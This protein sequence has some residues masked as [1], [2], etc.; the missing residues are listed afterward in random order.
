MRDERASFERKNLI[1]KTLI[2]VVMFMLSLMASILYIISYPVTTIRIYNAETQEFIDKMTVRRNSPLDYII[3][4]ETPY[5]YDFKCYTYE[6]GSEFVPGKVVNQEVINIYAVY[7]AK[8]FRVTYYVQDTDGEYNT[9]VDG[10]ESFL[11]QYGDTFNLPTGRINGTLQGIF[12]NNAGRS[13]IGWTIDELATDGGDA[14]VYAPGS[15]Q[16]VTGDLNYYAAWE[17][18][19]YSVNLWT[20]NDYVTTD[21]TPILEGG[22]PKRDGSG[23]FIIKNDRL[24]VDNTLST[25]RYLDDLDLLIDNYSSVSLSE[26]LDGLGAE[27][28]DFLGWY[29]EDNYVT[30]I[31]E[32]DIYIDVSSDGVPY[33]GYK[34]DGQKKELK[35]AREVG[36]D[37]DGNGV[38]QFDLYAKWQRRAYNITFDK[39]SN[40][41]KG[42]IDKIQVYKYDELYG[43]F[44]NEGVGGDYAQVSN[45]TR[46]GQK[47][48]KYYNYINLSDEN[49]ITTKTFKESY[50]TST[51]RKYKFVGWTTNSNSK[52]DGTKWYC[53]YLVKNGEEQTNEYKHLVGKDITLYAQ[54]EPIWEIRY[55]EST[56]SYS[57]YKVR[58]GI[59]GETV[60]LCGSAEVASWGWSLKY[61]KFAGWTSSKTSIS[62][63]ILK[64]ENQPNFTHKF[65]KQD[66]VLYVVW[67][68][69]KY[70]VTYMKNDGTNDN[71][72]SFMTGYTKFPGSDTAKNKFPSYVPQREGY[73]FEGWSSY[74][75]QTNEYA[76]E[77]RSGTPT[78]EKAVYS[79]GSRNLK[80]TGNTVVYAV[81]SVNYVITYDANGGEG[82]VNPDVMYSSSN[83]NKKLKMSVKG[84]G[85]KSKVSKFG[86][87]FKGWRL[88]DSA[89]NLNTAY[90][91]SSSST[92][93]F[94][95]IANGTYGSVSLSSNSSK[96]ANVY[97]EKSTVEGVPDRVI[98]LVAQ[99]EPIS[100]TLTFINTAEGHIEEKVRVVYGNDY[101]FDVNY[102]FDAD[103]SKFPN[104]LPMTSS[105]GK[106]FDGWSL[107]RGTTAKYGVGLIDTLTF[108]GSE[109]FI[110]SDMTFYSIF[111]VKPIDVYFKVE[112]YN[113]DPNAE[114][115]IIDFVTPTVMNYG[116][117]ITFPKTEPSE[118]THFGNDLYKF[119]HW[120][121]IDSKTGEKV[122]VQKG[123][124][125]FN[126]VEDKDKD[127]RSL[128]IWAHFE[129][130]VYDIEFIFATPDGKQQGETYT[131]TVKKDDYYTADL[132]KEVKK[133]FEAVIDEDTIKSHVFEDFFNEAYV[134]GGG[135]DFAKRLV[136]GQQFNSLYFP[137]LA[138]SK[139]LTFKTYWTPNSVNIKYVYENNGETDYYVGGS[140]LYDSVDTFTLETFDRET[141]HP[142]EVEDGYDIY[143]WYI[144]KD[145]SKVYFNLG[146]RL[147]GGA[148]PSM[149]SLADYIVWPTSGTD[150]SGTLY[151][152]AEVNENIT[153]N[154]YGT[155]GLIGTD[156]ILLDASRQ[157]SVTIKNGSEATKSYGRNNN[158]RFEGWKVGGLSETT[159]W[160][161]GATISVS[162]TAYPSHVINLYADM[163]FDI[164]YLHMKDYQKS[165]NDA[166]VLK[167]EKVSLIN[168]SKTGYITFY[169]SKGLDNLDS[170]KD[171]DKGIGVFGYKYGEAI[172]SVSNVAN[173]GLPIDIDGKTQFV[174]LYVYETIKI[175]YTVNVNNGERFSHET[176]E[177]D[178]EKATSEIV[179][180]YKVGY[181][182]YCL[183]GDIRVIS[184]I[185][186]KPDYEHSG[187]KKTVNGVVN[188]TV[189]KNSEI[190]KL[191]S[192][193]DITMQAYFIEPPI[194][195]YTGYLR[196]KADENT[197]HDITVTNGQ[198]TIEEVNGVKK[199][200][201]LLDEDDLIELDEERQG[202]GKSLAWTS[203]KKKIIGW[204]CGEIEYIL[205]AN[206]P[207]SRN[208]KDND[209]II[210]EAIWEKTYILSYY[211]D[212]MDISKMPNPSEI[213]VVSGDVCVV[214]IVVPESSK[215]DITFETWYYLNRGEKIIINGGDSIVV[216]ES[217]SE[218]KAEKTSPT[219]P[220]IHYLPA[221]NKNGGESY[222]IYSQWGK[223]SFSVK[224][225][226]I[227]TGDITLPEGSTGVKGTETIEEVEYNFV[228]YT[229]T[230]PYGSRI[231]NDIVSLRKLVT[232]DAKSLFETN[233]KAVR[234]WSTTPTGDTY[235]PSEFAYITENLVVY[236]VFAKKYSVTYIDA[237]SDFG[238]DE[239]VRVT[240]Y[241]F[242]GEIVTV[243]LNVVSKIYKKCSTDGK[244]YITAYDK[245]GIYD[246]FESGTGNNI[247]YYKV[248]GFIFN[249]TDPDFEDY[250]VDPDGD[251]MILLSLIGGSTTFT[252]G[253]GDITLTPYFLR[254]YTVTFYENGTEEGKIHSIDYLFPGLQSLDISSLEPERPNN[255]FLGWG[256]SQNSYDPIPENQRISVTD[257]NLE[258][259][260]IWESNIVVTFKFG[261]RTICSL[262]PNG[263][264]KITETDI[265]NGIKGGVTSVNE[266]KVYT[267]MNYMYYLT[268]FIYNDNMCDITYICSQTYANST[269]IFID[270]TNVYEVQYYQNDGVQLPYKDYILNGGQNGVYINGD[271][272]LGSTFVAYNPTG[273][274]AE[275]YHTTN[276][277]EY[278]TGQVEFGQAV[279]DI[280][281]LIDSADSFRKIKFTAKNSP[282]TYKVEIYYVDESKTVIDFYKSFE[283]AETLTNGFT[284]YTST[285]AYDSD[286][287]KLIQTAVTSANLQFGSKFNVLSP[288]RI[289]TFSDKIGN[290]YKFIGWT[291][292]S[293]AKL[294]ASV[295]YYS[296]TT[297]NDT[298]ITI[299]ADLVGDNDTIETIKLYPV[300]EE[301]LKDINISASTGGKI[302]YQIEN[303]ESTGMIEYHDGVDKITGIST[304]DLTI[305]WYQKL[306]VF[307]GTADT[308]YEFK[309]FAFNDVSKD[310]DFETLWSELDDTN[311]ITANFE[312]MSVSLKLKINPDL[313]LKTGIADTT[314]IIATINGSTYTLNWEN[315]EQTVSVKITDEVRISVTLGSYYE[316][317]TFVSGS[318]TFSQSQITV[319]DLEKVSENYELNFNLIASTVEIYFELNDG[320]FVGSTLTVA[321]EI[322]SGVSTS[323]D[324][325]QKLVLPRNSKI[326]LPSA[327]KT[328]NGCVLNLVEWTSSVGSGFTSGAVTGE[329][330][331]IV[332]FRA[333]YE[334]AQ[335][336]YY[337]VDGETVYLQTFKGG[338]TTIGNDNLTTALK[339]KGVLAKYNINKW[340]VV[341]DSTEYENG[342]PLSTTNT[343]FYLEAVKDPADITIK[344]TWTVGGDAKEYTQTQKYGS[345]TLLT[346]EELKSLSQVTDV[347][348]EYIYGW[349][350]TDGGN[351][352]M[353]QAGVDCSDKF[354]SFDQSS[355]N[356]FV[357]TAVRYKKYTYNIGYFENDGTTTITKDSTA[358]VG[359]KVIKAIDENRNVNTDDLVYSVDP[360]LPSS[361]SDVN[362]NVYNV[363]IGETNADKQPVLDDDKQVTV[364]A[365]GL[366]NLSYTEDTFTYS[367]RLVVI[368]AT[369]VKDFNVVVTNPESGNVIDG[370]NY[371]LKLDASAIVGAQ[372]PNFVVRSN[373]STIIDWKYNNATIK[374]TEIAGINFNSYRLTGYRLTSSSGHDEI[375]DI[376]DISS[377]DFL[378]VTASDYT[379]T[380]QWASRITVHYSNGED[381]IH[382]AY[383][384]DEVETLSNAKLNEYNGSNLTKTGYMLVGYILNDKTKITYSDLSDLINFEASYTPESN[385]ITLYPAWSEIYTYN[386]DVESV[387]EDK[388]GASYVTNKISFGENNTTFE[389][390]E[391]SV[392]LYLSGDPSTYTVDMSKMY[393]TYDGYGI[394]STNNWSL[395]D[396]F[397][398]DL[399]SD[400]MFTTFS[401]EGNEHAGTFYAV[402]EREEL[403]VIFLNNAKNKSGTILNET[404]LEIKVHL[405]EYLPN[406]YMEIYDETTEEYKNFTFL[407]LST[408]ADGSGVISTP[409]TYVVDQ[410]LTLYINYTYTY[411]IKFAG[412]SDFC[413]QTIDEICLADGVDKVNI[414]DWLST[415]TFHPNAVGDKSIESWST[416]NDPNGNP[417]D[418]FAVSTLT[419]DEKNSASPNYEITLY[420]KLTSQTYD[421]TLEYKYNGEWKS[422]R[423][424]AIAHGSKL[425][426]GISSPFDINSGDHPWTLYNCLISG[427]QK[428]TQVNI[429]IGQSVETV[430]LEDCVITSNCTLV[431]VYTDI[432]YSLT[433][434]NMLGEYS[435]TTLIG[436]TLSGEL[437]FKYG[438]TIVNDERTLKIDNLTNASNYVIYHPSQ[439]GYEFD[440]WYIKVG[441]DYEK[442]DI[443]S[444]IP[445]TIGS[446]GPDFLQLYNFT[447]AVE[448][449]VVYTI[450]S[451]TVTINVVTDGFE[452]NS[453]LGFKLTIGSTD[454]SEY[455]NNV[456]YQI[457]EG[458]TLSIEGLVKGSQA[459]KYLVDS[460][461]VSDADKFKDHKVLGNLT[462]TVKYILSTDFAKKVYF[463]VQK[464][465]FKGN[466]RRISGEYKIENAQAPY[467]YVTTIE[468]GTTITTLADVFIGELN[469]Y[470]FNGWYV[471]NSSGRI[472]DNTY[473]T[474][475]KVDNDVYLIA[476]FTGKEITINYYDSESEDKA[477]GEPVTYGTSFVLSSAVIEKSDKVSHSW[478]INGKTYNLGDTVNFADIN[479]DNNDISKID[480]NA[481]FQ[482][483]YTVKF[484]CD[485]SGF[486]V[487]T[488]SE[489][490]LVDKP[491]SVSSYYLYDNDSG[492]YTLTNEA[493]E[494]GKTCVVPNLTTTSTSKGFTGKWKVANETYDVNGVYELVKTH[495]ENYIITI[496][497]VIGNII[498]FNISL[499]GAAQKFYANKNATTEVQ[500]TTIYVE[501][502]FVAPTIRKDSGSSYYILA[503][504][505]KQYYFYPT[506]DGTTSGTP[507][508]MLEYKHLGW[509][510]NSQ[511]GRELADI[512]TIMTDDKSAFKYKVV[513][514][515]FENNESD[516]TYIIDLKDLMSDNT[517]FYAVWE[518]AKTVT[519]SRVDSASA[520]GE[521]LSKVDNYN[522]NVTA[523]AITY[524]LFFND[525]IGTPNLEFTGK[526]FEG[527]RK[528]GTSVEPIK[529]HI[530]L[531]SFANVTYEPVTADGVT[532]TINLNFDKWKAYYNAVTNTTLDVTPTLTNSK[533][534]INEQGVNYTFTAS[535]ENSKSALINFTGVFS[536]FTEA[537]KVFRFIGIAK[538]AND[539]TATLTSDYTFEAGNSYT[540]Y[541]IWDVIEVALEV[542][543]GNETYSTEVP[544]GAKLTIDGAEENSTGHIYYV[545]LERLTFTNSSGQTTNAS[546]ILDAYEEMKNAPVSS[547]KNKQV[548]LYWAYDK[549]VN[550]VF[551]NTAVTGGAE[552]Y[553]ISDPISP[554]LNS[555]TNEWEVTTVYPYVTNKYEIRFVNDNNP[556][557]SSIYLIDSNVAVDAIHPIDFDETYKGIVTIKYSEIETIFGKNYIASVSHGSVNIT[558]DIVFT[559]KDNKFTSDTN[560]IVDIEVTLAF[561]VNYVLPSGED[562]ISAI[563]NADIG[564]ELYSTPTLS[565]TNGQF[566]SWVYS[567]NTMNLTSGT[568]LSLKNSEK[569]IE[570][571][572][573]SNGV[574]NIK[575]T[576]ENGE[577]ESELIT[578]KDIY[579]NAQIVKVSTISTSVGSLVVKEGEN[580]NTNNYYVYTL[581]EN[582]KQLTL[583][584]HYCLPEKDIPEIELLTDGYGVTSIEHNGSTNSAIVNSWASRQILTTDNEGN[585]VYVESSGTK[586]ES[587]ETSTLYTLDYKITN[588]VESGRLNITT[589]FKF[590]TYA[591]ASTFNIVTDIY[592]YNVNFKI[593]ISEKENLQYLSTAIGSNTSPWVDFDSTA[594]ILNT[595][596][597]SPIAVTSTS[598]LNFDYGYGEFEED[599]VTLTIFD[600]PYGTTLS[601]RNSNSDSQLLG[602]KSKNNINI[603]NNYNVT[604]QPTITSD[605]TTT[606]TAINVDMDIDVNDTIT[607]NFAILTND[608]QSQGTDTNWKKVIPS[609]N[610]VGETN[611]G[612]K[613]YLFVTW[614]T[615]IPN[616]TS[617]YSYAK[618]MQKVE[619]KYR[620]NITSIM[621]QALKDFNDEFNT[622]PEGEPSELYNMMQYFM[623]KNLWN[624]TVDNAYIETEQSHYAIFKNDTNTDTIFGPGLNL[625]TILD[626]AVL[627]ELEHK[628]IDFFTGDYI[629][630]ENGENIDRADFNLDALLIKGG[631]DDQTAVSGY[632]Y[633]AN[634]FD[635][636]NLT[637]GYKY[638]VYILDSDKIKIKMAY[639][640]F[641]TVGIDPVIESDTHLDYNAHG[642]DVAGDVGRAC[643]FANNT[644]EI[645]RENDALI[646][647]FETNAPKIYAIIQVVADTFNINFYNAL[648]ENN[649]YRTIGS[650]TLSYD[651]D[652]ANAGYKYY[653]VTL[654]DWYADA[655]LGGDE[656]TTLP[657]FAGSHSGNGFTHPSEETNANKNY[658]HLRYI[659]THW[660]NKDNASSTVSIN[661]TLKSSCNLLAEYIEAI[662]FDKKTSASDELLEIKFK[663]F[664][665]NNGIEVEQT[666]FLFKNEYRDMFDHPYSTS[667]IINDVQIEFARINDKCEWS[668]GG[669]NNWHLRET[670]TGDIV[671][672]VTDLDPS[673]DGI[674]YAC[675]PY[676]IE[677]TSFNSDTYN[678]ENPSFTLTFFAFG[679]YYQVYNER[680][681][682]N[683]DNEREVIRFTNVIPVGMKAGN[684]DVT[685]RDYYLFVDG[686]NLDGV[687]YVSI[688]TSD[689]IS[690]KGL[691]FF[692]DDASYQSYY[693]FAYWKLVVDG[694]HAESKYINGYKGSQT[695]N[696]YVVVD[697]AVSSNVA[698]DILFSEHF[699]VLVNILD[700]DMIG[701]PILEEQL[702]WFS[703]NNSVN[704]NDSIYQGDTGLTNA[705][706]TIELDTNSKKTLYIKKDDGKTIKTIKTIT[707]IDDFNLPSDDSFYWDVQNL[708]D[709]SI[710]QIDLNNNVYLIEDENGP[711]KLTLSYNKSRSHKDEN[712]AELYDYG[713]IREEDASYITYTNTEAL[714]N[715]VSG[716]AKYSYTAIT[717]NDSSS[718]LNIVDGESTFTFTANGLDSIEWDNVERVVWQYSN[719]GNTWNDLSCAEAT[720]PTAES[721]VSLRIGIYWKMFT[722]TGIASP[723]KYNGDLKNN[724]QN[725]STYSLAGKVNVILPK[726][727][728]S[729]ETTYSGNTETIKFVNS[730]HS[731]ESVSLNITVKALNN[732]Y[733]GQ[734]VFVDASSLIDISSLK[735]GILG[736]IK[737]FNWVESSVTHTIKV[738]DFTSDYTHGYGVVNYKNTLLKS[739]L[740]SE[741]NDLIEEDS[742]DEKDITY[743]NSTYYYG[744]TVLGKSNTIE[745]SLSES[746]VAKH[747]AIKIEGENDNSTTTYTDNSHDLS[748][749]D[750]YVLFDAEPTKQNFEVKIN[751]VT[752]YTYT[753]Y[754]G[755]NV[756][757]IN[758]GNYTRV[759]ITT[760]WY[761]INTSPASDKAMHFVI[762][763]HLPEV[764]AGTLPTYSPTLYTSAYVYP[765]WGYKI[766]SISYKQSGGD[767][768]TLGSK[769]DVI[770]G[771]NSAEI[772]AEVIISKV[773]IYPYLWKGFS[774]TQD[775]SKTN[776]HIWDVLSGD[777]VELKEDKTTKDQYFV[778]NVEGINNFTLQSDINTLS[779]LLKVYESEN[780]ES[781]DGEIRYKIKELDTYR[782]NSVNLGGTS[783]T[784]NREDNN[785]SESNA[786]TIDKTSFDLNMYFSERLAVNI[787]FKNTLSGD[788]MADI[789]TT[790]S[791][792]DIFNSCVEENSSLLKYNTL[793]STL[794]TYC[795]Y[796]NVSILVDKNYSTL[797][798][799]IN[800]GNSVVNYSY[801][802]DLNNHYSFGANSLGG[803]K[804]ATN[805]GRLS[806]ESEEVEVASMGDGSIKYNRFGYTT[807]ENSTL[808]EYVIGLNNYTSAYTGHRSTFAPYEYVTYSF[809]MTRDFTIILDIVRN[810]VT[811]HYETGID[812]WS[813]NYKT[814]Y[815]LNTITMG[816]Q[817][818]DEKVTL[819]GGSFTFDVE[820]S[821]VLDN[822]YGKLSFASPLK[823]TVNSDITNASGINQ[824]I[825]STNRYVAIGNSDTISGSKGT[826]VTSKLYKT[827]RWF[828]VCIPAKTDSVTYTFPESDNSS[829]FEFE[830]NGE[831][832]LPRLSTKNTSFTLYMGI[833]SSTYYQGLASSNDAWV[834]STKR[835]IGYVDYSRSFVIYTWNIKYWIVGLPAKEITLDGNNDNAYNL[836]DE[837]INHGG[838]ETDAQKYTKV[839][840]T[841]NM[842]YGYTVTVEDSGTYTPSGITWSS[843]DSVVLKG[844]N[845]TF[846]NQSTNQ[847]LYDYAGDTHDKLVVTTVAWSQTNPVVETTLRLITKQAD[848]AG[849]TKALTGFRITKG[850]TTE[851]IKFF[852]IVP[853][854]NGKAY[855]LNCINVGY[856]FDITNITQD[857]TITPLWEDFGYSVIYGVNKSS[858]EKY[859][860]QYITS[861]DVYVDTDTEIVL[862]IDSVHYNSLRSMPYVVGY[863]VEYKSS[864][865]PAPYF[866]LSGM[867]SDG[868]KGEL[869]YK[870][871]ELIVPPE[872][873][874]IN[875]GVVIAH[876][877][878][879]KNSF[880]Y[881]STRGGQH[882]MELESNT[883]G[884]H[885]DY[886]HTYRNKCKYCTHTEDGNYNQ[887]TAYKY[888]DST[889]H[890][891]YKF[892][893]NCLTAKSEL[894]SGESPTNYFVFVLDYDTYYQLGNKSGLLMSINNVVYI[895]NSGSSYIGPCTFGN[896]AMTEW[897]TT[898]PPSCTASGEQEQSCPLCQYTITQTVGAKGHTKETLSEVGA[899]CMS[900]GT[901]T[902]HCVVCGLME[903][904]VLEK[905]PHKYYWG[906]D[907][908]TS[909]DYLCQVIDGV[910][911]HA[912]KQAEEYFI[913]TNNDAYVM[914]DTDTAPNTD[915]P[916][917]WAYYYLA[918]ECQHCHNFYHED[919]MDFIGE[920]DETIGCYSSVQ[921]EESPLSYLGSNW[922][923]RV[924]I[925]DKQ[926]LGFGRYA[927]T[928]PYYVLFEK[929]DNTILEYNY[930]QGL[931]IGEHEKE[932]VSGGS[933]A[934]CQDHK[935]EQCKYCKLL[936]ETASG[937]HKLTLWTRSVF[938]SASGNTCNHYVDKNGSVVREYYVNCEICNMWY[939]I[940]APTYL[941]ITLSQLKKYDTI[942]Y[943]EIFQAN[944]STYIPPTEWYYKPYRYSHLDYSVST[945]SNNVLYLE[946]VND[947][948]ILKEDKDNIFIE[949]GKSVR[950]PACGI[951]LTFTYD[952]YENVW[953]VKHSSGKQDSRSKS[954][955]LYN[956]I[957]LNYENVL[958][959]MLK[960]DN[961]GYFE[962]EDDV[963]LYATSAELVGAG[964]KNI[965]VSNA[966]VYLEYGSVNRNPLTQGLENL[967][968]HSSKYPLTIKDIDIISTEASSYK[969]KVY[970]K[971]KDE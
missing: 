65:K 504:G 343:V 569:Y 324:L 834:D 685:T 192:L 159:T 440:Y 805:E 278:K 646:N 701:N 201:C 181:D 312:V 96:K 611:I 57:D 244:K 703:V 580:S 539:S 482:Y 231:A 11:I 756:G 917:H 104:K 950:C 792:T 344:Y 195:K 127:T 955:W 915:I 452:Y 680:T 429:Q 719:D 132:E 579:L 160:G 71:Y 762:V 147:I 18:D 408:N 831:I 844:D 681:I 233:V 291:T 753:I 958:P 748:N 37:D 675:I 477:F 800:Q 722:V 87:V 795:K 191:T 838:A 19:T 687:E 425:Y 297:L 390:N 500:A 120:Y 968:D 331:R 449:Y 417:P 229:F 588:T 267:F 211:T 488:P 223:P 307:A 237:N 613:R 574:Y 653:N 175:T 39:N 153:I 421:V 88:K 725:V 649:E 406:D 275:K 414:S 308:N 961:G 502:G 823:L 327:T 188:S 245:G 428:A 779:V 525:T 724:L 249:D 116:T 686:N 371:T 951:L 31:S 338:S 7:T 221:S 647:N 853:S 696:G 486:T 225:R 661:N 561:T 61:N 400:E 397:K 731:D 832:T 117:L 619:G 712:S 562:G 64:Y 430:D 642:V 669:Y 431:L 708:Q 528:S 876:N 919:K 4:V 654:A 79:P 945:T 189:Y 517:T 423:N 256:E 664:D 366:L 403:T 412:Y 47:Q 880:G 529:G 24:H 596:Q 286:G 458:T 893:V 956:V 752:K 595:K 310:D 277:W 570:I 531:T 670:I 791:P 594:T 496:T 439:V 778:V 63:D 10:C 317:C 868:I 556:Y 636:V 106:Y 704:D 810:P 787:A 479:R 694:V 843:F 380:T 368:L 683:D 841:A 605:D 432:E 905:A 382:T 766:N 284:N 378:D 512:S 783:V 260:A 115:E 591:N 13:F 166:E 15:E 849:I 760:Y 578:S 765:D 926:E 172:Y 197:Y 363:Y 193:D 269:T 912:Y 463:L 615:V 688:T 62:P 788:S 393:F 443:S 571:V 152:Y 781:D 271:G 825:S 518:K 564:Q 266:R 645:K 522:V 901:K 314:E 736:D 640:Y 665:V 699:N 99:W 453:N 75:Y 335:N 723:E 239:D 386:F 894:S 60:A 208:L 524:S 5:G 255:V 837:F 290:Q 821:N 97:Y 77:L 870:E 213:T 146:E 966:D 207:V 625:Y 469:N 205:G 487:S 921:Y 609:S 629:K 387:I 139:T 287:N 644:L 863:S 174:Y 369:G 362:S 784:Y 222:I 612:N 757:A 608:L 247:E 576:L 358:L 740:N 263:Q 90:D 89:G 186:T 489:Y 50:T 667:L 954:L 392:N 761:N 565:N 361:L 466:V 691:Q 365:G 944:N 790:T 840:I 875:C 141:N 226:Y 620:Y 584:I 943:E 76:Q 521:I 145:N 865:H 747:K 122:K 107:E 248:F 415:Y 485:E 597:T 465:N 28:Y 183:D 194:G 555:E 938:A 391:H 342:D 131:F 143:K 383:T 970:K 577:L 811:I 914:L 91:F 217:I 873:G 38:Y 325:S 655:T 544:W 185:P 516:D 964:F 738:D 827:T 30:K 150:K 51:G 34:E 404:R 84:I 389:D 374:T 883:C 907:E 448:I 102:T 125:L 767:S 445:A 533:V 874:R 100:Y 103:A 622:I 36:K 918:Y 313:A 27:E 527:W 726:G 329:I 128:V 435:G 401:L 808:G 163:S 899:T 523:T 587:G 678:G 959:N 491:I 206:Y 693:T 170:Y 599:Y 411:I 169:S 739:Q 684:K 593:L 511:L 933:L 298:I 882:L 509:T 816:M 820:G 541:A 144:V 920:R 164:K 749:E 457:K 433:L 200:L 357:V 855:N 946:G 716:T 281:N 184:D 735:D 770:T 809:L 265:L 58:E 698:T 135:S 673:G 398:E 35:R 288:V 581:S 963:Y 495:A 451:Y 434:Y 476:D 755:Y 758:Q 547:D 872:T 32:Y 497:P 86:Y 98:K 295:S 742:F 857:I 508:N 110:K 52:V 81:W 567:P 545:A 418:F 861:G 306:T 554:I 1:I 74:Q 852:E 21:G 450:K 350:W 910:H 301:V 621:S 224:A 801:R 209:H 676:T 235:Y 68:P 78:G 108:S 885:S 3:N 199:S 252:I 292:V 334:T 751:D 737:I 438:N 54:W 764:D 214:P 656:S 49:E 833:D 900:E 939:Y 908:C 916:G 460:V 444:N 695:G 550:R 478:T 798:F 589:T 198:T 16:I 793:S 171:V 898:K 746:S 190:L 80:I 385:E 330:D 204:K 258:F 442:V 903:T 754:G 114:K 812:Y 161:S 467:N 316:M 93:S 364:T 616:V 475:I 473:V 85:A 651:E 137:V 657:L 563:T 828:F 601:L 819:P 952:E 824:T 671:D 638:I 520:T 706:I 251:G 405:G 600:V 623:F 388:F 395:L 662:G 743:R 441:E 626:R 216:D 375:I 888:Y 930:E 182:L 101:T 8:Y 942:S 864:T 889:R 862:E 846:K 553:T 513:N 789:M 881:Y 280:E 270:F 470:T 592:K 464:D 118:V 311:S 953:V 427:S 913:T 273:M 158:I 734:G 156:T 356:T 960:K 851:D 895:T 70:D 606:P 94:D 604:L 796:I 157:A 339:D 492:S 20:G 346:E 187:W 867:Y 668:N 173:G 928:G 879:N 377:Q 413:D 272:T 806:L 472:T 468:K 241:Y 136:V 142:F 530:S 856:T 109:P 965:G 416:S 283:S 242:P 17:K 394:K 95:F 534:T 633:S 957:Y 549:G 904:S 560:N 203:T 505:D 902:E 630:D 257:K 637:G 759:S 196:F 710:G 40:I 82:T 659:F 949:K 814:N 658:G 627:V 568:I 240:Q 785:A 537:Q 859:K 230:Y 741:L 679:G 111:T 886:P 113:A 927:L 603:W 818:L 285:F 514:G 318:N 72:N 585:I 540:L 652:I 672:N 769:E 228:E 262:V 162:A 884:S 41:A 238:Y 436:G 268:G 379:L 614:K 179:E 909:D 348:N 643:T 618:D 557:G 352:V 234:G 176:E 45:F 713:S 768:T 373:D 48:G 848:V 947:R 869:K 847:N 303:T 546:T 359:T 494:Y 264:G 892:C 333:K 854:A 129:L 721:V 551:N 426:D 896:H 133:K 732:N 923:D 962:W 929:S 360:L 14:Q 794:S 631:Q 501:D 437:D 532:I 924:F 624:S 660:S 455:K 733:Y 583:K 6:D 815:E 446:V 409:A 134:N 236:A 25:I 471:G 775:L 700:A 26:E 212:L 728:N 2:L 332:T 12:A 937:P 542:K 829:E 935:G 112:R 510:A 340:K 67:E 641:L 293:N 822:W 73:K 218:Y 376:E 750:I 860:K 507:I 690:T 774:K 294:G 372:L 124:Y 105:G 948:Y 299:D 720:I 381:I 323:Y 548:F 635:F 490:K 506:V 705:K 891:S 804:I 543:V 396:K 777:V 715:V 598:S 305:A 887:V 46:D 666:R 850:T 617:G 259:W 590:K 410:T 461:A 354:T 718:T 807:G 296:V 632:T 839:E 858:D 772:T 44:Y 33:M 559:T 782:L 763:S 692:M 573:V 634:N 552:Q 803:W 178:N 499:G 355:N 830:R 167:T 336:L 148:Y 639:G 322:F 349:K 149:S 709:N 462:I 261:T 582:K 474:S 493:L 776:G 729:V 575:Y 526:A 345:V 771:G 168:E 9:Q 254:A 55:Y 123:D 347:A 971:K 321:N 648:D 866:G 780:D 484:V 714:N 250:T 572:W 119:T 420:P 936:T 177:K 890:Y 717:S 151:V 456:S 628:T 370:G 515:K 22:T 817:G 320:G 337:Q 707:L 711:I 677:R 402:W 274:V 967:T 922:P 835:E 586:T 253:E 663:I 503:V 424:N 797:S 940:D 353:S 165:Y 702:N 799:S 697:T 897:N 535:V 786:I 341:G 871:G 219:S 328:V 689:N 243:D 454:H 536:D 180:E 140:V 215:P 351:E 842:L 538:N 66:Q 934:T 227:Y 836:Y 931:I 480:V 304:K 407:N 69:I 911:Y 367:Y 210:F 422:I 300:F 309:N 906:T 878:I 384:D 682:D 744:V 83:N 29:L 282:K 650:T 730:V 745:Y 138:S 23:Q 826:A 42:R 447:G 802:I 302:D 941:G 121:Y 154:Y 932:S 419:A 602:W 326:T 925:D 56:S 232:E 566:N 498:K 130:T 674:V 43:K 126:Y 92:Y 610:I 279:L 459:S 813:T 155:D 276:M 607:F 483:F 969:L 202:E 845:Y 399:D 289:P 59:E 315:M 481:N 246:T 877:Y 220:T 727:K 319:K 773:K 519:F 558:E 53:K